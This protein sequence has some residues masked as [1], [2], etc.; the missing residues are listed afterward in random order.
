MRAAAYL[1][2]LDAALTFTSATKASASFWSV[3][4][5]QDAIVVDHTEFFQRSCLL[6][7]PDGD[8]LPT[9]GLYVSDELLDVHFS[10]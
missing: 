3:V 1:I 10:D 8:H 2:T 5:S 9:K 7:S 6:N 4:A